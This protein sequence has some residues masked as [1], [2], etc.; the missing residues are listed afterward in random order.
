MLKP[1]LKLLAHFAANIAGLL[2]A[3]Y[4]LPAF[5]IDSD[6]NHIAALALLLM[7]ANLLIK[8]LLKLLLSPL[9]LLT[10]GLITVVINALILASIDFL[11]PYLTIVGMR[12][13]FWGTIIISAA[14]I[15]A[16]LVARIFTPK[17]PLL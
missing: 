4:W 11:S 6:P 14:N 12:A 9:I 5:H 1:L 15:I 7:A 2:L 17:K 13:L 8:P 10:L 3:A 16:G